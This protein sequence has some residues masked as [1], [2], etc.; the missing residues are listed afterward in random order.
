VIYSFIGFDFIIRDFMMALFGKSDA[1]H[2]Y[3]KMNGEDKLT[4]WLG[5]LVHV[6]VMF[7]IPMLVFPWWQVLIGYVLIMLAVG[8]IL[9]IVFQLAHISGEADF[10]EPHPDPLRVE[11]EWA[12]HQVETTVD[13]APNN[14]VLNW[15]IGGLNYQVE[16]HLLPHICHINYPRLAPIVRATCEEYDITYNCYPTWRQ[17]FAGHWRELRLL[18]K[19]GPVIEAGRVQPAA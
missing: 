3:P 13:F 18:A 8:L 4:F 11:N 9:G 14:R 7:V 6:V 2:V 15:Y 1:N 12:I 16:H 10:P 5:K 17:A 19:P